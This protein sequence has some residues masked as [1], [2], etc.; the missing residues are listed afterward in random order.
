KESCSAAKAALF[1]HLVGNGKQA[2]RNGETECLRG[3]EVD[4]ELKPGRLHDRKVGWLF[5]LEDTAG[6]NAGLMKR[7]GDAGSV[8]HQTTCHG[9]LSS[10]VDRRD[11]MTRNQGHDAIPLTV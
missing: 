2:R 7:V 4:D 3:R 6:V 11:R 10:F 5:A 8:A 9:G 1:D